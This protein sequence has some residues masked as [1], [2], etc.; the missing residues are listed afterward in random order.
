M[1]FVMRSHSVFGN[2]ELKNY[3]VKAKP[4][5]HKVHFVT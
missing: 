5:Y 2:N 4:H 1:Y 3:I